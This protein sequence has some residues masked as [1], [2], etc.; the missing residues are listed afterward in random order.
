[1]LA[2]I[3]LGVFL[4]GAVVLT[5]PAGVPAQPAAAAPS[6]KDDIKPILAANCASCHGGKKKKGGIDVESYAGVMKVVKAGE[7][8]KSRLVK[9]LH[10]KGARQMPPKS[11]LDAKEIELIRAWVAAGAKN[12]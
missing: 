5:R 4:C 10:G 7:P 11:T 1:M 12:N 3:A 9:S 6:Y 2:R 8:D